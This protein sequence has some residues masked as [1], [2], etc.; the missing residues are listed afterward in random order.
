MPRISRGIKSLVF[1]LPHQVHIT[2][3]IVDS[4]GSGLLQVTQ[5][6]VPSST[7]IA[8]PTTARKIW[9]LL[10]RHDIKRL[11]APHEAEFFARICQSPDA[12]DNDSLLD[13][14]AF[15]LRNSS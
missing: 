3:S 13:G 9:A 11:F 14:L 8:L 10:R 1:K 5:P 15:L 7:A 4:K 6:K 12:F 2:V